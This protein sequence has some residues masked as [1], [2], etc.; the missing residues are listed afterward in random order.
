VFGDARDV[1]L[2]GQS[3]GG[4]SVLS[5]LASPGARG[6]FTRAIVESGAY[7][8]VPASLAAAEATGEQFAAGTGCAGQTAACLR[9]LSV[10]T[11]LANENSRG[12]TPDIDGQVLVA[13]LSSA[14]ATGR[15]CAI[16]RA[17]FPGAVAAR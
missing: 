14:F 7:S 6:L 2:F 3:A 10:S 13:P 4:L 11:I 15:T 5:Q 9:N 16:C 12:Y 17:N 1:T 8:R